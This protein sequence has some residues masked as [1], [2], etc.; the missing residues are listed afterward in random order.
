MKKINLKKNWNE[1]ILKVTLSK[2]YGLYC[3]QYY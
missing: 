2:Q 3:K 1:K